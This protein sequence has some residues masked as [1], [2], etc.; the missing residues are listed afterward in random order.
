MKNILQMLEKNIQL[1]DIG[2]QVSEKKKQAP[3]KSMNTIEL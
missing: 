3:E 1:P 2:M